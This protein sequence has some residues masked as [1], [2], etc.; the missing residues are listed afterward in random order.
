MNRFTFRCICSVILAVSV[1]ANASQS[2]DK[3]MIE[4]RIAPVGQVIVAPKAADAEYSAVPEV[5]EALSNSTKVKVSEPQTN[6]PQK[7]VQPASQQASGAEIYQKYCAVCHT[8]G[9]AGAPRKGDK[10]AWQQRGGMAKLDDLVRS[11]IKGKNAMPARGTCTQC[12]D[13]EIKAA[14]IYLMS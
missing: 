5:K 11:A 10:S 12:S 3:S 9:V 6:T 2:N 14:V 13:E 8:S 1:N 4:K 7:I